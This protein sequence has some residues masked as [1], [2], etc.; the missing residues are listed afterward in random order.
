MDLEHWPTPH[1]YPFVDDEVRI[2]HER[3]SAQRYGTT[4]EPGQYLTLYLQR[5]QL[6]GW[7]GRDLEGEIQRKVGTA[8]HGR[9]PR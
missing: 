6:S 8:S 9:F 4:P 5:M 7:G 3:S 1:L 2:G